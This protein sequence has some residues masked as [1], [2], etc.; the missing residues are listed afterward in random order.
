VSSTSKL[1]RFYLLAEN[2]PDVVARFDRRLRYLYVSGTIDAYTGL[3]A[4]A[5]LGRTNR[6]AGVPDDLA[7]Q[8][9]AAILAAFETGE[10]QVMEFAFAAPT[11]PADFETRLVPEREADGS[12]ATVLAITRNVTESR[13]AIRTVREGEAFVRSVLDALSARIAVLDED[14]TIR[15]VNRAWEEFARAHGR[16][17]L[18][19]AGAGANYLDVA[20]RATGAD[21]PS[22][23]RA[24]RG[25]LDV[26][27]GR[28]PAFSLEYPC[29]TPTER[30]WFL[31]QVSPLAGEARGVVVSHT[32]V[33]D[34]KRAEAALRDSE[35]RYRALYENSLDAVLLTVPDGRVLAANPAACRLFG[36]SEAEICRRGRAGLVDVGDPRLPGLLEER[37]GTG[38]ARGELTF[39]RGD[40]T[41][42]L[43]EVSSSVFRDSHGS[44]RTSLLIRDITERKRAAEELERKRAELKAIY[45][46]APIMMCVVD[47]DRRIVFAN[48]AFAEFTGVPEAELVAGHACGIFGCVNA[49]LDPR[50][51]GFADNCAV[52][53]LRI[54]L[55]DTWATGRSHHDVERRLTLD[56]DGVRKEVVLLGATALIR[57]AGA[58]ELLLCLQDITRR[59]EA[60]AAAVR[61]ARQI[62]AIRAVGNELVRELN[63]LELL[64]LIHRRASEIIGGI[65]GGVWLWEERLQ[66]LV[67]QVGIGAEAPQQGNRQRLGEGLIGIVA[68]RQQ[69][70]IVHDYRTWSHAMPEVLHCS[71][72]GAVI[73]EPL[74]HR[75]QL[76]GVICIDRGEAAAGFTER[77]AE[78]LS[79]FAPHA[80]VAIANA[81]LFAEV[82]ASRDRLADL[83]RRQ[84]DIQENE[85]RR[86]ARELHDEIGQQLTGL[87]LALEAAGPAAPEVVRAGLG[88]A[89]AAVR[90]LLAQVRT[91]SLDLRPALL[92]DMGLLAALLWYFER[93]AARTQVRV[94]FTHAGLEGRP[95]P[96]EVETAAFRIVQ[97][98]LTNVARHA[99][100]PAADVR[101]W[102]DG[103]RLLVRVDDD[104]RGFDAEASLGAGTTAG[105]PGMRERAS[106][107]GGL[108]TIES[109]PG[110][111]TH[112]LAEIPFRRGA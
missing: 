81:Q 56:R 47:R 29:D 49:P 111:G 7:S 38:R 43:G 55:E 94:R 101:V 95:F 71:G 72:I 51:C 68:E 50:G 66:A 57:T 19:S 97:E 10:A 39:V 1:Y 25:I 110:K 112:I 17:T 98:A 34:T 32:D 30:L 52:C 4:T 86:L 82:A 20:R 67:C 48:R 83:S 85:R 28:R 14:G 78:I 62:E 88:E 90:E 24:I 73:A 13:R 92:D 11:G 6:E 107:M 9:D 87:N 103:H 93:Y 69:G 70:I 18:E 99:E 109:K 15:G 22:A 84:L 91:L 64:Q 60:E 53:S 79:L 33:T 46:H 45:D 76:V 65:G 106:L 80:A 41:P 58:S 16:R 21:A 3:S 89:Q 96:P 42:F 2:L 12:I 8:W 108:V 54:A 61:R 63:L 104:G 23:A 40:G 37:A 102:V 77:D 36:L 59:A 27:A 26:A 44:L 105:L 75:G 74:V 35:E 5:F 100:V 31:L